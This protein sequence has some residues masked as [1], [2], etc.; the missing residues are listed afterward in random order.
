MEEMYWRHISLWD[1][2]KTEVD[3]FIKQANK[4]Q[5]TIFIKCQAARM[6]RT[7]SSKHL[8]R[9]LR[10]SNK[11]SERVAIQKKKS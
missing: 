6:L 7:N 1:S 4:F 3:H 8:K 5:A 2:N 10:S 11:A 9:A